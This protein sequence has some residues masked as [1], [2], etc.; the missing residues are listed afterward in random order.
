[1]RRVCLLLGF[2]LGAVAAFVVSG[3]I[4]LVVAV[5]EHL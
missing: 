4:P 2:A 1:M 5:A 3:G